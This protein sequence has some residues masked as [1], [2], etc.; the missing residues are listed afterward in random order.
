MIIN[1]LVEALKWPIVTHIACMGDMARLTH[2]FLFN[3]FVLL[4]YVIY[5]IYLFNVFSFYCFDHFQ[6]KVVFTHLFY[7]N[8]FEKKIL[9]FC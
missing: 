7:F 8:N 5:L 1:H 3:Y 4:Y 6:K 9:L 2:D